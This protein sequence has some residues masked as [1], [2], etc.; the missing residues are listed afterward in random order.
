[1]S[2]RG[3]STARPAR[4]ADPGRSQDQGRRRSLPGVQG[5]PVGRRQGALPGEV[6]RPSFD[7][8][9]RRGPCR[10]GGE[11][12][13]GR[14]GLSAAAGGHD[15]LGVRAGRAARARGPETE[16]EDQ[17]ALPRRQGRPGGLQGRHG[18]GGAADDRRGRLRQ[19]HRRAG[20]DLDADLRELGLR[21]VP[22]G[23]QMA[24]AAHQP[25]RRGRQGRGRHRRRRAGAAEPPAGLGRLSAGADRA[26]RRQDR[27]ALFRR[28]GLVGPRPRGAGHGPR[29]RRQR[30]LRPRRHRRDRHQGPLCG[31]GPGGCGHRPRDRL[32]DPEGRQ[33]RREAAAEDLRRMGR[34][35]LCAGQ[36]D[37]AARSGLRAD[38]APGAGP[39]LRAPRPQGPQADGGSRHARQDRLQ[40]RDRHP[41]DRPRPEA[42][43]ARARH[44]GGG[45]RGHP[46][47]DQAG[48]PRPRGLVLRQAR[49]VGGLS[50]RLRPAAGSQPRGGGQRQLRR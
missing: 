29:L 47:P 14:R 11:L 37:P 18:A 10:A 27:H 26:G 20:R 28:L 40:G 48:Q 36:R 25:R 4:T 1:M 41:P 44:R 35:R 12:R 24:V 15:R 39:R 50:R 43:P 6:S 32:Q 17:A 30:P 42:R 2:P 33:E 3:S 22:E 7:G 21:L 46:A 34:R 31:R 45:G 13:G 5:L 16:A 38:S 19:A 49:P 8:H 23:R 9:R